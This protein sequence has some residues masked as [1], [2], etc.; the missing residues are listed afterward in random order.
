MAHFLPFAACWTAPECSCRIREIPQDP[1]RRVCPSIFARARYPNVS[2]SLIR[3]SA[4]LNYTRGICLLLFTPVLLLMSAELENPIPGFRIRHW[5]TEDGLPSNTITSMLQTRD[6]YLWIGTR[7]GLARFDGIRLTVFAAELRLGDNDDLSCN[8]LVQD[9]SGRLWIRLPAGL[10]SY[11]KGK[12]ASF[13]RTAFPLGRRIWTMAP[14]RQGGIWIGTD[15]GL[16]CFENARCTREFRA[17]DGLASDLV[18]Q[19]SEDPDGNLWIGCSTGRGLSWQRLEKTGEIRSAVDVIGTTF[20]G[21]LRADEVG[22]LWVT[23]AN[24][25]LCWE[26]GTLKRYPSHTQWNRSYPPC[27]IP[28]GNRGIWLAPGFHSGRLVHFIDGKFESLGMENGLADSDFRVIMLDREKSLWIGTGSGGVQQLRQGNLISLLTTTPTGGRQQVDSVCAGH[29]GNI[30]LGAWPALLKWQ[31]GHVQPYTNPAYGQVDI[32]ASPVAE[33]RAGQIWFGSRDNG[34]FTL[35]GEQVARVKEADDGRTT[36]K[37]RVLHEDACGVLWI[38]SDSGLSKHCGNQFVRYTTKQ[39]LVN[40]SILGIIDA[41]DG[42]LWIG[43][44]GGLQKV[45]DQT[46]SV[47]ITRRQGLLSDAAC[48]LLAEDD[49]TLWI[50]TPEGLNRLRMGKI[51]AVTERN[52]LRAKEVFCLLEDHN[53]NYWAN[54]IR[55][56]FRVRKKELNAVADGRLGTISC[57]SYGQAD[58]AVSVEGT[59]GFEPNGCQAPDGRMWFPTTR[60]VV[61]LDPSKLLDNTVPPPVVLEEVLADN[62]PIIQNEAL[63]E[64]GAQMQQRRAGITLPTGQT[65]V[66]ELRYTANTFAAAEKARFWYRMEGVDTEWQD[67]G[68][69]RQAFYTNLRPGRYRFQVKAANESGVWSDHPA[70]FAFTI[71]PHLRAYLL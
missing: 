71:S 62:H 49:G 29:D 25:L 30:W 53:G 66:L 48:P 1:M 55:G 47:G 50:G 59:G 56:I 8:D 24:E 70:L 37:V 40:N 2:R 12:F 5:T 16:K 65:R 23:T 14:R 51:D 57:V 36:W 28:D 20:E 10:V 3:S 67:A 68:T 43:T 7:H 9:T 35:A 69:R 58:G 6:G 46:F 11:E 52:G 15:E 27:P 54:S 19:L 38:G 18:G 64:L 26:H 44:R 31:S 17:R 34:L 60:G 22:R 63:T 4:I 45:K 39:G 21:C 32:H 41:P 33:D 61:V 42:G 13:P